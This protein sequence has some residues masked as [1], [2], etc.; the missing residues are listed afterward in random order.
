[1]NTDPIE[2]NHTYFNTT[3]INIL[4]VPVETDFYT[5]LIKT[6]LMIY[7]SEMGDKTFIMAIYFSYKIKHLGLF[8]IL[9]FILLAQ[10][11]MLILSILIGYG[12]TFIL[13]KS[14]IDWVVIISFAVFGCL[15]FYYGS[16]MSFRT[17]I[18]ENIDIAKKYGIDKVKSKESF[19]IVMT[20]TYVFERS[21]DDKNQI[22]LDRSQNNKDIRELREN[23]IVVGISRRE[24]LCSE[25]QDK[26]FASE[27]S[28][29]LFWMIFYLVC[30][31]GL[32]DTSMFATIII[33]TVYNT[34]GVFFGASLAYLVCNFTAIVFGE[35]ISRYL[36][37]KTICY[38]GGLIFFLFG[39]QYL[40]E[41]IQVN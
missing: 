40:I 20:D 34:S 35:F 36:N 41:K 13:N 19:S 22:L 31:G 18:N 15:Q 14:I 26:I 2:A 10:I 17:N 4:N 12:I 30:L 33:S 24:T 8:Y 39:M 5:S 21:E 29:V 25:E 3:N 27:S 7:V 6:L 38:I 1:M 32:G 11:F 23:P 37:Q 16:K 28:W 9:S